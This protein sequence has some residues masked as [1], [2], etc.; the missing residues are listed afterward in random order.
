MI[1]IKVRNGI[2]N[3]LFAYAFGEYMKKKCQKQEIRY[4]ISE[5]PQY[6]NG[7]Y[8]ISFTEFVKDANILSTKEVRRYLGKVLYFKRLKSNE[9]KI[10]YILERKLVNHVR[11]FRDYELVKEPIESEEARQSFVNKMVKLQIEENKNYVF[12]GFWE[13]I[14]YVENVK[15]KIIENLNFNGVKIKEEYKQLIDKHEL[16]TVHIRRGD[17]INESHSNNYPRYF[18]TY[19]DE[20]YYEIA[21]KMMENQVT[22]PLFVFFSDD[23]EY[24]KNRYSDMKNKVIIEGQKDY[25]DLY[26]MTLCK[27]HI[28]ANSTFSF[29]GAYAAKQ[30]GITVAPNI[31]YSY[32]KNKDS[33]W[34]KKFFE[35]PSWNYINVEDR[36]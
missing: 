29:W 17:Y 6:V 9:R 20:K 32:L 24:V 36:I 35:V 18:Y 33:I 7:R 34:S 27:H 10:T 4:D 19:C 5:L 13:D 14:R 1:I 11:L 21:I 23:I 16:V 12:D 30:D 26:L 28:I 15:N 3:Q 31:H 22:N 25:E 2:G 8:T